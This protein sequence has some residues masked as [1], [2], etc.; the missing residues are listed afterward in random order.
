MNHRDTETQKGRDALT[1]R[2]IELAIEVHRV[3]GPGLLESAYE[4]CLCYE[5]RQAQ[6]VFRRQA[7]LPVVY[8]QVR[9]DCGYRMDI[10]VEDRVVLELKTVERLLPIHDA[11]LLTY[12]RLAGLRT[13]LLI[14]F[15]APAVKDGLRRLVL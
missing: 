10:V 12:M 13:G 8:K 9:L 7:P 3:L 6:L 2:I 4:E 15:H 5:L 11:Q 14:N 1:E